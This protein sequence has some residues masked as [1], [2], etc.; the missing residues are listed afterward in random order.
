MIEHLSYSSISSY[1]SC[2]ENFRRHYLEKEPSRPT[3]A[4]VFGSAFHSTVEN[5]LQCSYILPDTLCNI[6]AE[7]WVQQLEAQPNCD[8]GADTPEFHFNEGIRLLTCGEVV[9]MLNRIAVKHDDDGPVIERKLEL[10]VPGVPIPIIGYM[11]LMTSDGIPGD[12]KTSSRQWDNQR[13]REELQPVFYLAALH[14]MG[15]PVP[16]L[17]FRH[18]V[19]TKTKQPRAQVL[20]HSHTFDEILWLFRLIQNVWRGIEREVFPLNPGTWKCDPKYCEFWSTCR[21]VGL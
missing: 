13:A 10:R 5:Y 20:E 11:D 14:Q 8:W 19:V 6:W 18:Y 2:G 15:Q 7:Q 4:L 17:R 16:G 12:F 9:D 21:G 3:P 1:L